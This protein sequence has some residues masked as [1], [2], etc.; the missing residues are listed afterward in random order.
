VGFGFDGYVE[1][2]VRVRST[3]LVQYDSN[4]YSV[5]ARYAGCHIS[6]RAYANRIVLLFGDVNI[7]CQATGC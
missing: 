5:P 4:R 3:C 1:K 7:T 6:L 2:A